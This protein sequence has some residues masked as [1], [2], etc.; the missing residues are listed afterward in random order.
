[1]VMRKALAATGVFAI[2]VVV[3]LAVASTAFA[4]PT[5]P[6]QD[7]RPV[8]GLWLWG[9][10]I[11]D[12]GG[13]AAYDAVAEALHLTPVEL[14]EKLHDGQTLQEI[15]AEQGVDLQDIRDAV[16]ATRAQSLKDRIAQAVADGKMTQEQADWLLQG[17]EK[18]FVPR[19][20]G[21]M[22]R[23]RGRGLRGFGGMRMQ[24]PAPA[25]PAPGMSF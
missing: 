24:P 20:W 13:V 25:S 18:G 11:G 2:V 14:F 16:M 1:M 12:G 7:G 19:G 10:G 3:A 22:G 8:P 4:D 9:R 15:A 21:E 23:F 17:I 6:A 5:P